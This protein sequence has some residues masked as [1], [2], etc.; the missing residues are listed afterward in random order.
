MKTRTQKAATK[1]LRSSRKALRW[2]IALSGYWRSERKVCC[3]H[4]L[5]TRELRLALG[6]ARFAKRPTPH[7]CGTT[8]RAQCV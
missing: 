2:S 3:R 6:T 5:A 8:E 1:T 4:P 7:S